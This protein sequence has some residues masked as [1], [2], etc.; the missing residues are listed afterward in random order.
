MVLILDISLIAIGPDNDIYCNICCHKISW[1]SQYAGASDCSVIPGDDG[2]PNNCPRCGGKVNEYII[3]NFWNKT[4]FPKETI[5][6]P[7][8]FLQFLLNNGSFVSGFW[9]WKDEHQKRLVS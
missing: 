3:P 4:L 8:F 6:T 5:I 2:E 1:P 7:K 9:G